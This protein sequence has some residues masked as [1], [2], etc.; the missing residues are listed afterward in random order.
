MRTECL[1]Q[2]DTW[3]VRWMPPS[4]RYNTWDLRGQRLQDTSSSLASLGL[5]SGKMEEVPKG[6]SPGFLRMPLEEQ[7]ALQLWIVLTLKRRQEG[8]HP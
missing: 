3:G 8:M 5:V 2:D 1:E 4:S 7:T 6:S